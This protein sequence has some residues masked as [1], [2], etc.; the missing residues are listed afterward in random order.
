MH[1]CVVQ[2][3]LLHRLLFLFGSHRIKLLQVVEEEGGGRFPKHLY[4]ALI[5]MTQFVLGEDLGGIAT[6]V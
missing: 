3:F 6:Q 5:F 1:H 2:R 4:A